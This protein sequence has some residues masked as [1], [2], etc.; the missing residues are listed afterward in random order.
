MLLS[1][2]TI[3]KNPKQP[4]YSNKDIAVWEKKTKHAN[5]Y[6]TVA[7]KGQ[8]YNCF[9]DLNGYVA[10]DEEGNKLIRVNF[11]KSVITKKQNIDRIS[12]VFLVDV[13]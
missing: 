5:T 9:Y 10:K 2:I 11:A 1:R 4:D 13:C 7:C 6:F 12:V 8:Y 3:K